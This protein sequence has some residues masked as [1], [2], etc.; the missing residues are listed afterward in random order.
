M[1]D[2]PD[3]TPAPLATLRAWQKFH[4]RLTTL[5]GG[6]VLVVLL[7]TGFI[8][9][10]SR[11]DAEI[12]AVQQK[13]LVTA[14][15]V[16]QAIDANELASISI[17]ETQLTP[18]H[19]RLLRHFAEV[20]KLDRDIE[21]IY[22]LRP[23][24]E[25]T[26]LRFFVDY[27]RE[28]KAGSPGEIYE[29]RNVPVLLR[30]TAE[31]S[32]EDKPYRDAFGVTL[33]GYAPVL[34][35]QGRSIA[36]VGADVKIARLEAIRDEVLAVVAWVFGAASIMVGAVSWLVATNIRNPLT[37][38]INAMSAIACG[39]FETR[40]NLKRR[41]EFG[42]VSTYLDRMAVDLA[43]REFIRE[44]FGKYVSP[45]VAKAV[46]AGRGVGALGGEECVVT[47]M[48]CDL[49]GYS[50]ISE[51]LTPTQIVVLLNQYLGAMN[52]VVDAHRGCVIEYLGDAILAVFGAPQH[53]TDHSQQAVV[54]ALRMRERLAELNEEWQRTGEA[55]V[56]QARGLS[57]LRARIG[58]HSGVVVAGNLG[59]ATRMKF[60][61]IGD[62]VNVA[63]R[64]EGLNKE[65]ETDI[66][67]SD[68]VSRHLS[69]DIAAQLHDHG[70]FKVKGREQPV[71][72]YSC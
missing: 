22:V 13:L 53:Y 19:E 64:L 3:T 41:D 2:S 58:L 47:V 55:R 31:P 38:I 16:A 6:T 15:S 11:V 29:A 48:F 8:F 17:D 4:V 65:L 44:T 50:T 5:Y 49:R 1:A 21:S 43:E 71:R 24:S 45:D 62:V 51:N 18:V 10:Q 7:A 26:R 70:E 72:V 34:D 42:V 28:G 30:G 37:R 40:T 52:A 27:V 39:Q 25:P 57:S 20:V 69:P 68:S 33:S 9:Y 66:L 23:T 60:A 12:D 54:C 67:L 36:V 56:W 32:V 61:I 59:S 63:A 14:A 35:T 46:L